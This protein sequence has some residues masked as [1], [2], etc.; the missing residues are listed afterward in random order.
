LKFCCCW[1]HYLQEV[2]RQVK[3]V[4]KAKLHNVQD[5]YHD[6]DDAMIVNILLKGAENTPFSGCQLSMEMTFPSDYPYSPP[7]IKF[8]HELFH[9]NIW[10][11]T[12]ELCWND[13]DSTGSEYNLES[14]IGAVNTLMQVPNP[15][16]PANKKAAAL[17]AT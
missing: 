4:K 9:P 15:D 13:N 7:S 10:P 8:N 12:N 5:I 17:S 14:I 1:R 2:V 3:E 6:E 11:K 16:S